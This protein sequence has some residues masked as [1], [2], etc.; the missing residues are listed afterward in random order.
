MS[1]ILRFLLMA[2]GT[3]L[4]CSCATPV[5]RPVSAEKANTPGREEGYHL[6]E[7]HWAS[8]L[9]RGMVGGTVAL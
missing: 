9:F 7:N 5:A 6:P 3:L 2:V 1:P 4:L 8:Q